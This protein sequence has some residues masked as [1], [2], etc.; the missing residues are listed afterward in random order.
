MAKT[1]NW[2]IQHSEQE[3]LVRA[4]ITETLPDGRSISSDV[5]FKMNE[6]PED[7]AGKLRAGRDALLDHI[8]AT[9]YEPPVKE[10]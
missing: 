4:S 2:I 10:S 9:W 6:L 1:A 5:D 3:E 8:G 7:V